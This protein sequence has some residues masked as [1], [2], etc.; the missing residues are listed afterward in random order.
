MKHHKLQRI[1][2]LSLASLGLA[3]CVTHADT[4]LVSTVPA[5]GSVLSSAPQHIEL[6]FSEPARVTELT[7]QKEG[8]Q[9]A[10][11]VSIMPAAP[12]QKQSVP[13]D[14]ADPGNYLVS[15]RAQGADARVI[16]G[17]LHFAVAAK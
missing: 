12:A 9:G 7:V 14:A 13:V 6:H 8:E 3:A 4:R 17:T 2:W 5:E 1:T 15:W 11:V 16:T 10:Q